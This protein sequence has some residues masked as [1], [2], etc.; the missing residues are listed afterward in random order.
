MTN[1]RMIMP[2]G[3]ACL[4]LAITWPVFSHPVSRM[5]EDW[6]DGWRGLLYGLSIGF[7]IMAVVHGARQRRCRN[8]GGHQTF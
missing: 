3:M 7:N 5:A 4:V 2:L 1:P 6:S 8:T